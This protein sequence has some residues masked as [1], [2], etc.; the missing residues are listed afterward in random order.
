MC[1]IPYFPIVEHTSYGSTS[2]LD[3]R[4]FV[5]TSIKDH[6]LRKGFECV[7]AD[8][9]PSD[10]EA[11]LEEAKNHITPDQYDDILAACIAGLVERYVCLSLKHD[12]ETAKHVQPMTILLF[13]TAPFQFQHMRIK[14]KK[15]IHAMMEQDY[16]LYTHK[17]RV[18]STFNQFCNNQFSINK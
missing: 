12:E 17:D 8:G 14:T 1:S 9:L 15:A 2:N 7:A 10:L 13:Q 16:Y 11:M 18:M 5:K 6:D 3:L 4:A